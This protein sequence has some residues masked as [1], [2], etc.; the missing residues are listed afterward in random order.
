MLQ[1]PCLHLTVTT[2]KS[3]AGPL[4]T[5]GMSEFAGCASQCNPPPQAREPAQAWWALETSSGF[6]KTGTPQ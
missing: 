6:M 1:V 4:P 2:L 5:C 3:A